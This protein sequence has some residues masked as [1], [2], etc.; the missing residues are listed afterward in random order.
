VRGTIST[1]VRWWEHKDY[2]FTLSQAKVK[3]AF[4]PP[5]PLHALVA[6]TGTFVDHTL[7]YSNSTYVRS[8]WPRV[9]FLSTNSVNP[10]FKSCR[11]N[12]RTLQSCTFNVY[13]LSQS[14]KSKPTMYTAVGTSK[15][16][17]IWGLAEKPI[18]K[19]RCALNHLSGVENAYNSAEGNFVILE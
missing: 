10:E 16:P 5:L 3:N 4:V 9:A 6:C 1:A 18:F 7:H 15:I 8:L 12:H 19:E 13:N 17:L 2:H 14:Y 11:W